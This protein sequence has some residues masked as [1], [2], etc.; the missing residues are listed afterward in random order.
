MDV[1]YGDPNGAID[2]ALA[3][4]ALV[5]TAERPCVEQSAAEDSGVNV[6]AIVAIAAAVVVLGGAVLLTVRRRRGGSGDGDDAASE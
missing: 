1:Q 2:D 6:G 5:G 4:P 3:N